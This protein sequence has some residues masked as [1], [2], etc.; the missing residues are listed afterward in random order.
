MA[1][2][3]SD[4]SI[5]IV[6]K[7]RDEFSKT[8]QGVEGKLRNMQPMFTK[9]AAA[10]TLAFGGI[11]LAARDAVKAYQ[12][13]ETATVRLTHILK[14]AVNASDAQIASL[15]EQAEA[16]E[17]VGVVSADVVKIG[18]GTFA[19]F[20]L[21]AESVRQL[22]PAF[23]DMVVAERGVNAT[24]D[25]MISFANSLGQAL[26]GN[27]MSLT[28]RGFILDEDTK[29]MI[30]NGTETE[31]VAALVKVLNSTYEGMNEAQRNTAAGM[32]KGLLMTLGRMKQSIGE[33]LAPAIANLTERILPLIDKVAAWIEQNPQ[34]AANILIASGAIAGLVAVVGALGLVL[35][36]VI[37]GFTLM[38]GPVGIISA[39]IVAFIITVRNLVEIFNILRTDMGTVWAGIK[40]M[41]KEGVNF[42]IGLAESWANSWVKAVNI[43][44]G[45]LNKIKFSIPDWVPGIGGK[46]FGINIDTIPEVK[47]PRFEFGGTVP[48]AVGTPV[49]IMA[50]G[51]ETVIPANR[52]GRGGQGTSYSVTINNP[53]VRSRADVDYL[54]TQ[55]EEALRDVSRGHKLATI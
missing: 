22:T 1:L 23:L 41:F 42:L 28:K 53:Q 5:T 48:G 16:L 36:A 11:A 37:A 8:L 4:Q 2:F 49:P 29:A 12:E 9:M 33:G 35:P 47:L 6:L 27:F 10:G 19:T 52:A 26:Q 24:T 13:S 39:A 3:G 18:Q 7:A 32:E 25:D 50:H 55:I 31:R 46:S 14:T 15:L 44:I 21:Q 51:Q 38:L 54:R 43:I 17:R 30:E 40:I 20:D 34:L 45:A